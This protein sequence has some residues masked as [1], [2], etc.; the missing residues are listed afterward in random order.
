M[1]QIETMAI[2][3]PIGTAPDECSNIKKKLRKTKTEKMVPGT[4]NGVRI[5]LV[6]QSSPLKNL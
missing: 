6:F 3:V 1:N 2:I 4:N 5:I